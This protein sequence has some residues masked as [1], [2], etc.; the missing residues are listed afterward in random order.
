MEVANVLLEKMK[1][2]CFSGVDKMYYDMFGRSVN[3]W[4]FGVFFRFR[5]G[6]WKVGKK[7]KK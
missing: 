4:K 5:I 2:N 7:E 6:M 3:G 1:C